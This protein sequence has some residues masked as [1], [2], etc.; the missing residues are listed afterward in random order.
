MFSKI[1]IANR[2]EIAVR[3]IRACREMGISTVAVYSTADKDALHVRMADESFCIGGPQV[4]DSYLNMAAILEVAALS[5]AQAIHPGYGL[6]SENSKFVAL[7]KKCNIEFIGPSAEMIERLGDKDEARKTMRAAGVPV[8]PGSD[9]IDDINEARQKAEEIGFPLL[10]KARSGGGGR[11]IRRVDSIEEFDN[12][13]LSAKAEAQSAFGDGAVYM[14]KFLTPVKHVEMQL[15]SDKYG[16]V[17]CLGE[18]E[19]SVQR[20]NQKLSEES[21]SPAITPD[22]RKKMMEAAAKAARAVGYENAGTVEFLLDKDKNFYFMEMNTRLQVEHAVTEMVVGIDI[23]QW[24]IRIAS[25]AKLTV[26]QDRVFM[27]GNAI[28][29]RINAEDVDND[30]RP[31]CGTIN[32]IHIPGGPNV[33]FD[34]AIYQDYSVPPYYDSM[35][36]KLIVQARSRELAIRKMKM[37]LSE[38]TVSGIKHNRNLHIDIL[39]DPEFVSGEY[40]TGFMEERKKRLEK[41]NSG[42]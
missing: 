10:V 40:T 4:A 28:E 22:I 33:R 39:S 14:E 8:T 24:Q 37:A 17:V 27:H 20:K 23:V 19:C 18:R 41:K 32:F 36:G 16:N 2:G 25:G 9:I 7:C 29:C 35:I 6:L 1:L 3:I 13:F 21:P 12:A 31:G 26:T 42:E 30:F 15:L 34:T 5:G 11:G 38:L